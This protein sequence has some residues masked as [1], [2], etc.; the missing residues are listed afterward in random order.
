LGLYA[1]GRNSEDLPDHQP[2]V[3]VDGTRQEIL[4]LLRQLRSLGLRNFN[5]DIGRNGDQARVLAE[6][7]EVTDPEPVLLAQPSKDS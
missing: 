4:Q 7:P 6:I 5:V 1:E 2:Q 3:I